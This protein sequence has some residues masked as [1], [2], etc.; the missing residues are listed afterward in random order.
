MAKIDEL[1]K[2][3]N[4]D[5]SIVWFGTNDQQA[6]QTA[7]GIINAD[8]PQWEVE[9]ARRVGM[10]MDKLT[11]SKGARVYW[12]E[13]PVMRDK[14]VNDFVEIINAIAKQEAEKR[15]AVTYFLTRGILGRKVDV[16]SPNV[17]T[18]EGKMVILRNSDGIHLSRAGADRVAE[19]LDKEF[20]K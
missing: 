20:Y 16:Y 11:V 3:F 10:V 15:D 9:Y 6:M 14:K 8:D 18:P 5:M 13:L 7:T 12:L 17:I 1:V 2:E 4:P 19:A